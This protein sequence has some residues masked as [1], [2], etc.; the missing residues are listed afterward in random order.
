MK[1]DFLTDKMCLDVSA[2]FNPG[3]CPV[4]RGIVATCV[5]NRVKVRSHFNDQQPHQ[6]DS[7]AKCNLLDDVIL[8]L[9]GLLSTHGKRLI[10]KRNLKS[11]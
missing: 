5:V 10:D 11:L 8:E 9:F 3:S 7:L 4:M 2:N 6:C 1:N